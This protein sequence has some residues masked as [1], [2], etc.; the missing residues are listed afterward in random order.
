M[1]TYNV[2][3]CEVVAKMAEHLAL[4]EGWSSFD[5]FNLIHVQQFLLAFYLNIK[6]KSMDEKVEI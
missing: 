3:V 5:V 2:D 6:I 4:Q 1:K